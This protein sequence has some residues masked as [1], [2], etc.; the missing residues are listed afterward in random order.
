M[1]VDTTKCIK[2]QGI[3]PNCDDTKMISEFTCS[4]CKA[5][6]DFS[7]GVCTKNAKAT[8]ETGCFDEDVDGKCLFCISG[9]SMGTNG[10]CTNNNPPTPEPSSVG[11]FGA[12][13][14]L[15]VMLLF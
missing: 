13:L 14:G 12:F 1:S 3:D 6:Y 11:I 2:R 5:G 9:Y 7:N 4:I 10:S 8:I 15:M